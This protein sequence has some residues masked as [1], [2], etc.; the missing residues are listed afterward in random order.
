MYLYAD[1]FIIKILAFS[2]GPL[3]GLLIAA[4]VNY[5]LGILMAILVFLL[6]YH[7]PF[8]SDIC[9]KNTAEAFGIKDTILSEGKVKYLGNNLISG[10]LYLT[11]SKLI[12]INHNKIEFSLLLTDVAEVLINEKDEKAQKEIKRLQPMLEHKSPNLPQLT[13]MVSM[14]TN[15]SQGI[16][17]IKMEGLLFKSDFNFEVSRPDLWA[18]HITRLTTVKKS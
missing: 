1:R 8:I 2:F 15:L 11:T 12:F 9:L 7:L 5:N 14:L 18:N 3:M 6:T 17:K 16:I 13:S 4:A 10:K